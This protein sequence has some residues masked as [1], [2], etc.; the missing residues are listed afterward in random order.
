MI[1]SP[2]EM[3]LLGVFRQLDETSRVQIVV[4]AYTQL[5]GKRMRD[6]GLPLTPAQAAKSDTHF[7]AWLQALT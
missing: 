2:Q 6:E 4:A 3:Q 5:D 7:Q 1:V